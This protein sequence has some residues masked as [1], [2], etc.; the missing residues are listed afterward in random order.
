MA[1][2][3]L[4]ERMARAFQACAGQRLCVAYSGG[5]DS[6]V[7]LHM[8]ARLAVE[9]G[10]FL[11]AVHVHHGLSRFAD[12]WATHC[13]K[14]CEALG[15]PLRVERVKVARDSGKGVEAAAR[16]ERHA[17]F[18]NMPVEW[19][20]LAQHADDQ[21]E[22][23][24]HRLI[25]GTGVAGAAAMRERDAAR[26]LWRPL[27]WETRQS[28]L[29]WAQAE[30]L[31]WIEDDSNADEALTRNFLRRQILPR[32]NER[33]PAAGA[34]LLRATRHFAEAEGLLQGLA[35]ED[36]AVLALGSAGARERLRV[37]PEARIRNFVRY[38][39]AQFGVLAPDS[40]RLDEVVQGLCGVAPLHWVHAG[41]AVCAYQDQVWLER[42]EPIG[43]AACSWR[44]EACV[45][46]ADGF[47]FFTEIARKGA[48]RLDLRDGPLEIKAQSGISR[49]RLEEARP[50]RRFKQVCQENKIPAWWR[51]A[52]PS[53]WQNGRL[54]WLGGVG[55]MAEA[56]TPAG[57]LGWWIEWQAPDG[58]RR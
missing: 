25:R 18:S 8:C 4:F 39:L 50:E 35:Q 21:V 54:L 44:G 11:S 36:L 10:F 45:A 40:V 1:S 33:F 30:K 17:V 16:A 29:A 14:T 48:V 46:W 2:M 42:A 3:D 49:V 55:A 41:W 26:R 7:L 34:N 37:L 5:L 9:R 32:L 43:P 47:L 31:A 57:E 6:T 38:Y 56:R 22:T 13:Q 23:L 20:L 28:L 58:L 24:V 51:S 15:I 27:L 12:D 53:L 19:V 52:M